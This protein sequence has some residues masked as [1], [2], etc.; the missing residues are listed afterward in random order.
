M[1]SFH[2][3]SAGG[4]LVWCGSDGLLPV[5]IMIMAGD[6]RSPLDL[7]VREDEEGPQEGGRVAGMHADLGQDAPGLEVGESVLDG[8]R[9]AHRLPQNKVGTSV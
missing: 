6:R 7:G 5:N 8:I 4:G 1:R 2:P 9:R 3:E